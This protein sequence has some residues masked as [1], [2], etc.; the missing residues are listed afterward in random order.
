MQ[1]MEQRK[2]PSLHDGP[3]QHRRTTAKPF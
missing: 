1:K 3:N 2:F